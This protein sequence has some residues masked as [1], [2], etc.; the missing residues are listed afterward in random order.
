MNY[1]TTEK[2]FLA[3]VF[4]FD[5]FRPFLI[6]NKVIV[7][8]N[9]S[10][11]KYIITKKEAKTHLIRWVIILQEFDVEIKDKK[12]SENLVAN[13]FSRLELENETSKVHIN[14]SF[15]DEQLLVVSHVDW[16]PWFTDIVN[17]LAVGIIPSDLTSQQKKR[18]FSEL[19]HYF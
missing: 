8:M 12:G 18:F 19:R 11:I 14:D 17:Y 4:A 15:L 13:H 1:A 2:Y 16:T 5:K 3:I 7:F 10:A 9:H 6:G